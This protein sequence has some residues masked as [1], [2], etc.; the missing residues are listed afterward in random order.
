M[1]PMHFHSLLLKSILP[2][3]VLLIFVTI[4]VF[5]NSNREREACTMYA[6]GLELLVDNKNNEAL[7]VM[8]EVVAKYPDT[9]A[10]KKAQ[11]YIDEYAK[12]LDRSGI[13]GFYLGTMI[14][15]TWAAYSIPLIFDMENGVVLGTTGIV[16]VG[17]GIYAS[18]L[19]SRNIDMSLGSDLWIEFIETSAIT[20][21]QYAYFI[22]GAYIP[23]TDI[24]EKGN[25]AGL[26]AMSLISRGLTYAYIKGKD[27]S[28]GRAFTVINTY[29]WTQYYLW[30]ALSQI[31][32]SENTDLNYSLGILIPDLAALGSYHLW[33]KAGWS[34]QRTG[35]ISVSGLGGMLT[36]I[37]TNMILS[38][39]FSINVS[40]AFKASLV[41]G[42]SLAGKIIGGYATSGMEPDAKADK[43]FFASISLLPM[44]G[45]EGAGL[46]ID[47]RS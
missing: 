47:I 31:F 20:N 15:T 45:R 4:P 18:W 11:E 42:C 30:I 36:G 27:P 35:I 33:D 39:L 17:S 32:N 13:I 37:F 10:A 5:G 14:T 44:S 24:R 23:D 46:M 2:I 26:A 9:A 40:D 7:Q 29:A 21:F 6:H 34:F 19:L 43:S 41:L 25:I 38:E 1:N 8:K 28:S 12:R 22:A 3:S 16:G